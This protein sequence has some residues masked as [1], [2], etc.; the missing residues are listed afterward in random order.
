MNCRSKVHQNRGMTTDMAK[1]RARVLNSSLPASF[2]QIRRELAREPGHPAGDA[3][4]AYV[5]VAPLDLDNRIDL[6]LWKRHRS[7][8][9]IARFRPGKDDDLGHLVHKAGGAWAFQYDVSGSRPDDVGYHFSDEHFMPGEY[10]SISD[11]GKMHTF[12]VVSTTHL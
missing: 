10:V 9:R 4:I 5:I 8:C 2:R 1:A 12:H 7:A 3:E 11:D 6:D